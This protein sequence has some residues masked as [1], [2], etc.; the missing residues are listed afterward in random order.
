MPLSLGKLI[1]EMGGCG[2]LFALSAA[3]APECTCSVSVP[4]FEVDGAVRGGFAYTGEWERRPLVRGGQETT[5]HYVA[6]GSPALHLTVT[7]RSY[8]DS[9]VIRL[10]QTL[11]AGRPARLT[12]TSGADRIAY[13]TL[14]GKPA[15]TLTEVQ[16]S[17]FDPVAHSYLPLEVTYRPEEQYEGQ[18]LVGPIAILHDEAHSLLVAYEHGADHPQSFLAYTLLPD[19]GLELAARQ[20]NYYGGQA[21][22]P[23]APF[24]SV[25]FELALVPLPL[26]GLLRCYRRFVLEEMSENRE[27]RRPYLFYNTWNYQERRRYF[28]GQ[29]YLESMTQERMLAEI[30][31]AHEL[32]IDVFVIDTGWYV[33]TGDWQVN[34]ERFPDGLREVRRRLEAYGMKLGLWFNPTVAARTSAIYREHPEYAITREGRPP[35]WRPIWETEESTGM[36]L[37]SG[38][39]DH[40]IETLVRLYD[41]LGVRYFKW[42]GVGQYG[43]DSPLHNHGTAENSPEER[44]ACYAYEMGRQM[45]RIAEEVGKR[46]PGSIVD[47]DITEGERFV[48]L[49]FLAAGKLYL[50]NNGPYFSSLDI[51]SSVRIDPDTINVFFYPGPVRPRICRTGARYDRYMPS[52]LF[53]TH[54][55]PDPPELSQLNSL[56]AL[57]LGGNGIWGDLPALSQDDIRLLAGHLQRYKQ[58]ATAAVRAYPRV[59]GFPGAS[60]EIHE[61]LD[62]ASATGLVAFFT[63]APGE[64][65]HVTHPIDAGKLQGVEGAD[66]WELLPNGRLKLT[67][68]LEPNGARPVYVWGVDGGQCC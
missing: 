21:I 50:V 15:Q 18:R 59:I 47:F 53:L 25:W 28:H 40:F 46:C 37:A 5:L 23:Q 65:I 63:V 10:R 51:P 48:G 3:S 6:E 1:L 17:H 34:T 19:G 39:A 60:P 11:T 32:G 42:D 2:E 66:A 7:V 16:L 44:A 14:R 31:V 9:P 8:P 38:Y 54:Y 67:V 29:P 35:Q 57:M 12:K 58:V 24:T 41:E 52:V 45:I 26:E 49:G 36:C 55:L 62:P 33:K 68:N 30:D 27:T 61:K 22:G 56:G 13:L 43:C 4:R 64:F 20:G